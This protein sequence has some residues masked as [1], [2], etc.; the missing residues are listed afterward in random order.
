MQ[1]LDR[2]VDTR[3]LHDTFMHFGPIL[4]CKVA[5]DPK[6]GKSKGYGFVHFETAEAAEE[7]IASVNGKRLGHNSEKVVTV[8]EF[9]SRQERGDSA[10]KFTN[11]YVKNLPESVGTDEALQALFTEYGDITSAVVQKVCAPCNH[12]AF[13]GGG[14]CVF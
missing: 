5:T 14:G 1:N 11:I 9:L 13:W 12:L 10:Q 3:T 6:D 7:A 2:E 8:C 4:S